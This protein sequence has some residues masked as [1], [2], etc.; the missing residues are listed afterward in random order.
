M[1]I[2][3]LIDDQPMTVNVDP[4]NS[5][6]HARIF[7]SAA[8]KSFRDFEGPGETE[9]PYSVKETA[10]DIVMNMLDEIIKLVEVKRGM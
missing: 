6:S 2:K 3:N 1:S 9:L 8:S 10:Y 4:P 7:R 5:S